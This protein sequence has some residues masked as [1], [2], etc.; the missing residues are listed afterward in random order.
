LLV[1][2]IEKSYQSFNEVPTEFRADRGHPSSRRVRSRRKIR[3]SHIAAKG[4]SA[5]FR[6]QQ[7]YMGGAFP[8]ARL[9][10]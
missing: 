6:M 3:L 10:F 9:A 1:K 4:K 5:P 2:V 8:V 7:Y